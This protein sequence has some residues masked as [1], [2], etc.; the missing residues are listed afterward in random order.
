MAKSNS[1]RPAPK[2]KAKPHDAEHHR[3]MANMLY[4]RAQIHSAHADLLDAKNPKK[5]DRSPVC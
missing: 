3:K 1:K 2:A 5:K 4:A